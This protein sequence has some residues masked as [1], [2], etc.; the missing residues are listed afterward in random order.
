MEA[1]KFGQGM[2]IATSMNL[3]CSTKIGKENSRREQKLKRKAGKSDWKKEVLR[4]FAD[5]A[6]QNDSGL[7]NFDAIPEWAWNANIECF[8]VVMPGGRLRS[9]EKW[10]AEDL[11]VFLDG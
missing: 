11:G 8:K 9:V 4:G 2:G 5:A 7:I 1:A 10:N 6:S 3:R